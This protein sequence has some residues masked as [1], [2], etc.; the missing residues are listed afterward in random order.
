M[1]TWSAASGLGAKLGAFVTGSKHLISSVGIPPGVAETLMGVF[2]VS[3]AATTLDSATRIQRYIVSELAGL[4]KIPALG[5]KHPATLIAVG[6]A[7]A[8]AFSDSSGKG[9]LALWPLFGGLNQL[10]GGLALLVITVYLAH[11]KVNIIYTLLPMLFMIIM[12]GWAM[13]Y[14]VGRLFS[15]QRWHLESIG[16]LI[17]FFELWIIAEAAITLTKIYRKPR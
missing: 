8:L 1:A 15:E 11:R 6:A 17:L 3:F 5:K 9:A 2:I 13:F 16:I 4:C 10:L 7:F 14:T 12:T